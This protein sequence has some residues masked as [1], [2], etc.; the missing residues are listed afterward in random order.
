MN[1]LLISISV[2]ATIIA[3]CGAIT[4]MI[5]GPARVK[6]TVALAIIIAWCLIVL[7]GD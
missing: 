4:A 6:A 3:I 1:G 7:W 5:V 2:W